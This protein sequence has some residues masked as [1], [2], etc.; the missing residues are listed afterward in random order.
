MQGNAADK[1]KSP[2]L[3]FVGNNVV[4][5]IFVAFVV[6]GFLLTETVT[7]DWFLTELTNRFYRNAFLVVALIIPVI[8]GLGMNFGITVGAMAGQLA[9]ILVRYY[10][11]GGVGGMAIAALVA[12]AIATLFGWLVGILYNHTKGQEMIASLIVGYFAD[13]IYR[14]ILLYGV[15]GIIPVRP[16]HPLVV[17]PVNIGIR[18]TIDLGGL[19]NS[20]DNVLE[21][22]FV[23]VLL[24]GS[25]LALLWL[26]YG[27]F[28]RKYKPGQTKLALPRFIAYVAICLVLIGLALHTFLGNGN[29]D[30]VRGVPVAILVLILLAILFTKWIMTTKLGQNF[31]ACGQDQLIAESNG[32]NVNKN[33]IIATIF[34][35]VLGALGMLIY[36][37][38]IGTLNVY[39]QHTNIG[40]FSVAAILVG[41]ASVSKATVSQAMI[42]TLLFNAMFIMSPEI[43][44]AVFGQAILGEYFRT[45]MVYGVIGLALG[46]YVWK[47]NKAARIVLEP[48]ENVLEAPVKEVLKK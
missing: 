48:E 1:K 45:F 47:A 40:Y 44:D 33:R 39:S 8:C 19:R 41:G 36:I 10:D 15:G 26:L 13:G 21:L 11:G 7:L 4:A 31:R 2:V 37:Q 35:T 18:S 25:I 5:I 38:N 30:K 3:Q 32:I 6:V 27:Q 23:W 46:L 24:V 28:L 43:G 22:P 16:G 29:L 17:E 14:F 9:I 12:I 34:S 42:G 20:L